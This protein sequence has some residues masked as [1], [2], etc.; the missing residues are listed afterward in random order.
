MVNKIKAWFDG[1]SAIQHGAK[2]IVGL[3]VFGL[4]LGLGLAILLW[5]TILVITSIAK[6]I[7]MN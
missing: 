4:A 6:F 1:D 2:M 3:T 5:P 7:G